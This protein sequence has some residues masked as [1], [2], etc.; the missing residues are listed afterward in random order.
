LSLG[1]LEKRLAALKQTPLLQSPET[2]EAKRYLVQQL[3][4]RGYNRREI[5][6]KL[7]ISR[8]TVYN[9]LNRPS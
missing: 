1:E 6:Q 2:R 9:L 4:A 5:A 7:N 3:I 8:K